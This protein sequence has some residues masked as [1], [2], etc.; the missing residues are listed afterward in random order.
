MIDA[1]ASS[2]RRSPHVA[3]FVDGDADVRGL[4]S[5]YF[6]SRY[7]LTDEASDGRE[8]LAKALTRPPSV[9][10]TEIQL[11]GLNGFDLC[12]VLRR[13]LITRETPIIVVTRNSELQA[14]DGMMS[15]GV[16][17]VFVKPCLPETILARA[18]QLL[19]KGQTLRERSD[20]VRSQGAT[21]LE[22]SGQ[23]LR[24]AAERRFAL[25]K[26]HRR[27]DTTTP[28]APPPRLVCPDCDRPLSY[29][30]SFIGGVSSKQP[31]QWDYF[32]CSAGCGGFQ[33]RQR[34]RRLRRVS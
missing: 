1:V 9:V 34:T 4:Y 20:R 27:H 24:E 15:V 6:R 29:Q 32:D 18:H 31:E 30:R 8:A 12:S 22:R 16:D 33:Y 5:A 28:P 21:R 25:S 23:L 26:A 11:P 13:D 17:E 7:W 19:Q 14:A 3:L 2:A 10:V